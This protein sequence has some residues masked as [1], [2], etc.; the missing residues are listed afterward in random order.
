MLN[1][2]NTSAL[3]IIFPNSYDNLL[4]ELSGHLIW[5]SGTFGC[6]RCLLAG[7]EIQDGLDSREQNISLGVVQRTTA[8]RSVGDGRELAAAD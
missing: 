2:S 4:P 3:G 5:G 1:N 8:K 7:L 6:H